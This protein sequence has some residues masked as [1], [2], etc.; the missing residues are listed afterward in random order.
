MPQPKP[1]AAT[2]PQRAIVRYNRLALQVGA[3]KYVLDRHKPGPVAADSIVAVNQIIAE[4]KIVFAREPG[5]PRLAPLAPDHPATTLDLALLTARFVAA[6]LSFEERHA[7][8][9]PPIRRR[10]PF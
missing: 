6:C 9:P 5:L 7:P 4:A 8:P 2:L 3:L 10:Y 1:N